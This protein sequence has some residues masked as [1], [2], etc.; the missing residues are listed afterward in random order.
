MLPITC[1]WQSRFREI[2]WWGNFKRS[3]CRSDTLVFSGSQTCGIL[4]FRT[5]AES[6]FGE[7]KVKDFD[8]LE[9]D[10]LLKCKLEE[11]IASVG[12]MSAKNCEQIVRAILDRI[13]GPSFEQLLMRIV[14]TMVPRD[15]RG[16]P[17]NSDEYYF[18]IR[19]LFPH[20]PPEN[21][22]LGR[23]LCFAMRMCVLRIERNPNPTAH[24]TKYFHAAAERDD[25]HSK[26]P[27]PLQFAARIQM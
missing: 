22:V 18:A 11:L 17:T 3:S 5:R 24:R 10:W 27:S 1:H 19:D 6:S 8:R 4:L 9:L 15:G 16:P 13:G 21:D 25:T 7:Q 26:K 2:R 12:P 23:R 20:V 14:E